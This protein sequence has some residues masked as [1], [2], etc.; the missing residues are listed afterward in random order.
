MIFGQIHLGHNHPRIG[1]SS[2]IWIFLAI[3]ELL[4]ARNPLNID[5]GVAVVTVQT[6][7]R[8]NWCHFRATCPGVPQHLLKKPVNFNLSDER[9]ESAQAGVVGCSVKGFP[10]LG[11]EHSPTMFRTENDL[12][13]KGWW[14]GDHFKSI[15]TSGV[16]SSGTISRE[17][18]N[19]RGTRGDALTDG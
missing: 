17:G 16:G 18:E 4:L 1:K 6:G 10:T 8:S 12:V 7:R 14:L 3:D 2:V 11:I 9:S 15:H 19:L 13:L 5:R